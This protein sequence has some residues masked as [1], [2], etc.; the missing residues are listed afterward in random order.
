MIPGP[1]E[2]KANYS[3]ATMLYLHDQVVF[4][5]HYK[6]SIIEPFEKAKD[7][8]G[9]AEPDVKF[10]P[11]WKEEGR[12]FKTENKS[13]L[14]SSYTRP[15]KALVVAGNISDAD[16]EEAVTVDWKA[17]GVAPQSIQLFDG[18]NTQDVPFENGNIKI[19]VQGKH[20]VFLLVNQK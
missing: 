17:L 2:D 5:S 8:F 20:P 11:Y 14:F 9:I 13:L 12:I 15:G 3:M 1:A 16:A 7:T 4:F 10:L 19:K 18:V 6:S